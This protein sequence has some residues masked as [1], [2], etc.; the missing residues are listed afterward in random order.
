MISLK[1]IFSRIIFLHVIAVMITAIF[2][3]LVLH[4]FL[5]SAASD[6]HNTAMREQADLVAH[7]LALV[8]NGDWTLDLPPALQ[9]LYSPAYGRYAYLVHDESGR[10]L[11]SS[12]GERASIISADSRLSGNGFPEIPYANAAMSGVSLTKEMGGR[13]VWVRVGEDLAHRDVIM[14]DIVAD[15]FKRV[16]WIT[17]SD[18][19]PAVGYRYFDFPQGVAA[20]VER[21]RNGEKNQSEQ[22]GRASPA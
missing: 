3:P 4:W 19:S 18:S 21:V 20:V 15:F 13:K 16:G 22:N 11:F 14:D 6:L 7:Y 17:T 2:M 8:P 1:S 9:D 12:L 5:K 10:I